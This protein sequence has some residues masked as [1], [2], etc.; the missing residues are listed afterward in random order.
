MEEKI[1]GAENDVS[2]ISV[3][4]LEEIVVGSI[5]NNSKY[6]TY[7]EQNYNVDGTPKDYQLENM[8]KKPWD[9][10]ENIV[11]YSKYCYRKYGIIMRIVNMYRDF[12]CTGFE[13]NYKLKH[14]KAKAIIEE[15]NKRVN[16]VQLIRDLVYEL[17][18]TGNLVAYDRDGETVDIYPISQVKIIPLQ[19]SG[20]QYVAY[21]NDLM[22]Y[23]TFGKD[24]DEKIK[25][26][27]PDEVI[28]A[29]NNG[30]EYAI[31]DI[32]KTYFKKI[33]CSRYE[34]F[35]LSIIVPAFEDLAHKTLLKNAERTT[36][37]QVID[38]IL[39]TQVGDENYKPTR[40]L[41]EEYS[42]IFEG[43][44]GSARVTVPHYVN[45]KYVEPETKVFGAEKFIEIDKD[46]LN[47]LGVSVSL[48]R[49]E[50]GGSYSDGIVN[51][52]GLCRSIENVREP[53]IDIINQLYV[54]ELK[55]NNIKPQYAPTIKLKE[56]VIDKSAK[57]D[58]LMQLFDKTN[59]PYEVL[60]E[61]CDMDFEHVK[62]IKNKEK[63]EGTEELFAKVITNNIDD[64]ND[65]ENNTNVN[66]KTGRPVKNITDRKTDKNKSNNQQIRTK[67]KEKTNIK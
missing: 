18:L 22:S 57:T 52:T 35:G 25:L 21:K 7:F 33:N 37:N 67:G 54:A 34:S 29:M 58:L 61:G 65:E 47:T 43:I 44:K 19:R 38:K 45:M 16:I 24:I 48:L 1:I 40:K 8:F 66:D 36:A 56:V 31:L 51:F 26:A 60:Y 5:R 10:V 15:F 30:N 32:D 59:L 17:S 20:K 39:L 64:E 49:G 11:T 2:S 13:L 50:G 14:K 41:L 23:E 12:S 3:D 46:I 42:A 62:F 9:N 27:Y 53:V 55:R 63:E 6:S 28:D 4:T